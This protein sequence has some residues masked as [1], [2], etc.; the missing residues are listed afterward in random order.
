[1]A[2]AHRQDFA[3][4]GLGGGD[5]LLDLRAD[6]PETVRAWLSAPAL[7][8]AI[9][10]TYDPDRDA[11][12]TMSNGALGGWFDAI[13]H[14]ETVTPSRKLEKLSAEDVRSRPG[15]PTSQVSGAEPAPQ[16]KETP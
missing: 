5:Y 14:L 4:A 13:V 11:A 9:G 8:R 16:A 2:R 6:A 3:D 7:L 12:H 10:P 1:M 15:A